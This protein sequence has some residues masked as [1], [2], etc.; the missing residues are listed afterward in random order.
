MITGGDRFVVRGG[1]ARTN[2][3][4]FLNIA[5]NIAS[6]FPFVA[7]IARQQ[8]IQ[9]LYG[10]AEHAGGRPGRSESESR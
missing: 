3:Y 6:S 5:L 10:A 1:Y 4:A 8:R 2:D 7:A 9:R